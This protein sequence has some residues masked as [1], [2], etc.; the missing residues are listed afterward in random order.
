MEVVQRAW[1]VHV[2]HWEPC[3]ALFSK[4]HNTAK[5]LSKWSRSIFSNAKVMLHAALLVILHLD[6][7]QE[8]RLLSTD[9]INFRA[10]LKRRAMALAVVERAR[11]KQSA[12]IANIKEGDA[13][14]KFFHLRINARRRKN[15]ILRL[16]NNNGWVT[17]HAAKEEIIQN[18][19]TSVL[20]HGAI[21]RH[22][23]NWEELHFEYPDL[24]VLGEPFSE[25]EVHTAIK[26]M[27]GEK[28]PGPDGFTG[29]FF[30]KGWPVIKEDILKVV[31]RF[32]SLRV[33]SFQW[34]NSANIVLLPKKEG[35][36][37]ISD[38]RPISLIHSIAKIIAKMLALR[39][40][41]FMNDL[42]S[43]AQSAF[44]K[45]RSIHDNFLY[46]KNLATRFHRNK[47]PALLFKL[48]I[49]KAFDSIRWEFILDLLQRRGFPSR[50]RDWIAAL[51]YTSSSRVL[52]NGIA[53]LPI[54][55]GRGLRQGDPLSPLL[56]VLAIDPLAQLLD[57]STRVGLL[58]RLRGRGPILRTSLYAD[59]AAVFVA[60]FK[61]DIDNLASIL[62]TF[63]EVTGLCTNFQ[64][65]TVVPIHC[66]GINLDEV[67]GG[68]PA[69]RSSFPMKYLGLPL[70]VGRLRRADFQHLEDKCA[71]KL[72]NWS[73]KFITAAGRAALVKSVLS[74]QATYYLTPLVVPQGTLSYI[75][76]I[77][78]AF[79]WSAKDTTTG[80]KCKV[81]WDLVCRPKKF[82]GLGIQDINKFATALRLRWPWQEW[83]EP[84][85]IWVG[86]GNPCNSRDMKVFYDATTIT[87]G[88]GRL[89]PFWHAP[90]LFGT[91]PI[92]IAPLVFA[93]SKRKNWMV[94]QALLG[95][96][97]I[98]K[99]TMDET[100]TLVHL[101]QFVELWS[102]LDQVHLQEN[103]E[104]TI[105]WN[106]TTS[107]EYTAKSAYEFQF[108]GLN[109]SR[110]FMKVWRAWAPPKVK[111]FAWLAIQ[112]RI[113]TADRLEKRG[114][115]NCGLCPLCNQTTETVNHLFVSCRYTVRLWCYVKEWLGI[116]DIHPRQWRG[117]G[118]ST[119]NWWSL[120]TAGPSS[121]RK[122]MASLTL[123][124]SW[125][126][127][128]ERNARV[129]QHKLAPP[130]VILDII[131]RETRL[132]VLAGARRLGEIVPGE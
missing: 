65:S 127:W 122:A 15:H 131:K 70:T 40:G 118:L 103:V 116:H 45:S 84:Q 117:S 68:I 86:S 30:K 107:G 85:K 98:G 5:H 95:D 129:F 46:V 32:G 29:A 73:G 10:Q 56:F 16:R 13:N 33:D 82:G 93:C 3:Q 132:W 62:R 39:L 14:T 44:I 28:A 1:E 78:R 76:K 81:K 67:L 109:P 125:E 120:M 77:Q 114:W 38:F 37:D 104:D 96:A 23:F 25:D 27:P 64:K 71:G 8:N 59:D 22:D 121:N 19:F 31:H 97:W 26:Q 35:A 57:I 90:W 87:V 55:H 42:V 74:S 52:L 123:L 60:P 34:L 128:N 89:T 24:Q 94:S 66:G 48:D 105:S 126:V 124:V 111:F 79:L 100:F 80:A 2:P 61:V 130:F 43:N 88:N 20:G 115:Q 110:V 113:W 92:A 72:P 47:T 101:H 106:L 112:N 41:P 83:K 99:I 119:K 54:T 12:R 102:L 51:F 4:L 91:K 69:T 7:A 108:V 17:D 21:R 75:K 36:E 11:K 58:H 63:G 18:H 53:G 50:F 49:R 9:E 6:L